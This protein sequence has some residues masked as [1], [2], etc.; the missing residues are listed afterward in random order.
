MNLIKF[1]RGKQDMSGHDPAQRCT[2]EI[3]KDPYC[4][5]HSNS[6]SELSLQDVHMFMTQ[7]VIL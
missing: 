2:L 6:V 5:G 4:L 7:S 3:F 1:G